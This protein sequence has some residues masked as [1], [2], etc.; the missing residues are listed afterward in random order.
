MKPLAK[1]DRCGKP[2]SAMWKRRLWVDSSHNGGRKL[3]GE[4]SHFVGGEDSL[5]PLEHNFI[6]GKIE[7]ISSSGVR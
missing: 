2:P 5:F 7:S 6:V 3:V 4:P 1:Q